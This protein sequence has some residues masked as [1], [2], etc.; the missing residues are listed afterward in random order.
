M[1]I[2]HDNIVEQLA[3]DLLAGIIENVIECEM[4]DCDFES[5]GNDKDIVETMLEGLIEDV[6]EELQRLQKG[7]R[8]I[9]QPCECDPLERAECEDCNGSG[10]LY[11]MEA[12]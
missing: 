12:I 11:G 5:F 9:S 4:V 6:A 2:S 10:V 7:Q 3:R 1:T 8:P